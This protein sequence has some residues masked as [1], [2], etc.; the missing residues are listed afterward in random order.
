MTQENNT[1]DKNKA[2]WNIAGEHGTWLNN[3][4]VSSKGSG[5][6]GLP[7]TRNDGRTRSEKHECWQTR[8]ELQALKITPELELRSGERCW[9]TPWLSSALFWGMKVT[10]CTLFS[11]H[12][13]NDTH[14]S[15]RSHTHQQIPH[16]HIWLILNLKTSSCVC[17]LICQFL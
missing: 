1:D 12:G 10:L 3:N 9:E 6:R 15:I 17:L 5:E 7:R 14:T 2:V 13:T 11:R 8:P 4:V 16:V